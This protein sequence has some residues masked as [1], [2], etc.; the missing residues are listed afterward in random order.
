MSLKYAKRSE[1]TEQIRVIE[2]KEAANKRYPDLDYMFH[3]PNG[4]SR[5]KAEAANLKRMGTKAGVPDLFLPGARG[6]Y[7][8]LFIEMKYGKNYPSENQIRF[9]TGV[10]EM[11][12]LSVICYSANAATEVLEQYLNLKAGELFDMDSLRCKSKKIDK[13]G[14]MRLE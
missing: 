7:I 14:L 1:E 5:N 12:Y 9:L 11:G 8:G 3:V 2:W 4:G 13:Y 6:T 10:Q